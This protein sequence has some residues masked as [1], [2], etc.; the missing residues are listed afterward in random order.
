[1]EV[2]KEVPLEMTLSEYS[3]QPS[4]RRMS[5]RVGQGGDVRRKESHGAEIGRFPRRATTTLS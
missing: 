2:C 3:T 1:M 4:S 5:S